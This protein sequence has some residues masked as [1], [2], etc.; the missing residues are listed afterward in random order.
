MQTIAVKIHFK[1]I[2]SKSTLVKMLRNY[3]PSPVW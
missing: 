1:S 2:T 3:W